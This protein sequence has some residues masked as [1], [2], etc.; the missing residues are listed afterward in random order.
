M[1]CVILAGGLGTR[2]K[3]ITDSIPKV[4]VPVA[5]VPFVDHQLQWIARHGVTDVVFCIGDKGEQVRAHVGHDRFGARV[6]YVEDGAPLRGTAG[7]LRRA[8][9]A[10]ELPED[11]LV[12]YGDSFLPIDFREPYR[13]FRAQARP[14]MMTVLRNEGRWDVGNVDY[15]AGAVK[16]YRKNPPAPLPFIDYGLSIFRREVIE[17]RVPPEV[18]CDLARIQEELSREGELAGFEVFERFYEVGSPSGLEDLERWL[19]CAG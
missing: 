4:L 9:D 6:R 17:A 18:P 3:P 15:E 13:A 14:A 16:L 1:H 5:G 10:G 11:F 19:A 8:L 7:A 2:L 12:L